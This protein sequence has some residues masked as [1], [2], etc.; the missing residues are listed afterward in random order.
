MATSTSIG[1]IIIDVRGEKQKSFQVE[2]YPA[3]C[4]GSK[5]WGKGPE[6]NWKESERNLVC[7]PKRSKARAVRQ[8]PR[9]NKKNVLQQEV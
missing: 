2:A 4:V 7:M 9:E 6:R 5:E 8:W 1:E 3:I